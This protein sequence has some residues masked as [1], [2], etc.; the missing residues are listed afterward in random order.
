[1]NDGETGYL[2]FFAGNDINSK[3]GLKAVVGYKGVLDTL[4]HSEKPGPAWHFI[5]VP[6]KGMP[7]D[8][9]MDIELFARNIEGELAVNYWTGFRVVK[10]E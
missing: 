2:E 10:E 3:W 8:Q 9:T 5:R 6:L 1:M 7:E 4:I